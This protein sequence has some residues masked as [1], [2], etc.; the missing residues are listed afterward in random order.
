MEKKKNVKKRK[1]K[2]KEKQ[3]RQQFISHGNFQKNETWKQRLVGITEHVQGRGPGSE[4]LSMWVSPA[5]GPRAGLW[6]LGEASKP[7]E[8][9]LRRHSLPRSWK[10]SVCP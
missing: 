4:A 3:Q 1:R 10:Y 7:P 5:Q 8:T 9:P 6:D 2:E